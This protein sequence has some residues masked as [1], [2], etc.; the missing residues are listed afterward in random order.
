M[1]LCRQASVGP[2]REKLFRL[3]CGINDLLEAKEQRLR[4]SDIE[5]QAD[6]DRV[7]QIAYDE[8][9]LINSRNY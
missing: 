3:V 2:D 8:M 1:E 9:L 6:G 5:A 4:S 7:F